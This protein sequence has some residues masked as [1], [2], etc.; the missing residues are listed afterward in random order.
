[1]Q[2]QRRHRRIEGPISVE[3]RALDNSGAQGRS[4]AVNISQSGIRFGVDRAMPVETALE[5]HLYVARLHGQP[6]T[7]RGRVMWAKPSTRHEQPYEVGVMFT[8]ANT[9]DVSRLLK[10]VYGYWHEL[11]Q[12]WEGR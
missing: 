7:T 5:L 4:Q 6:V 8:D 1:M 3:Y 11:V 9:K 10:R 12:R 2:D